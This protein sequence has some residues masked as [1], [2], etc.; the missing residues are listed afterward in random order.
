MHFTQQIFLHFS[1]TLQPQGS[2][3]PEYLRTRPSLAQVIEDKP[4][5]YLA[6]NNGILIRCS[7]FISLHMADGS[8]DCL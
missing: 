4:N 5:Q 8:Y 2:I 6:D 7:Q 1:L 3:M